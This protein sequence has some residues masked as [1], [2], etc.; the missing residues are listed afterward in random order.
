MVHN[1]K[2]RAERVVTVPT[3]RVCLLQSIKVPA[4]QSTL[5]PVHLQ[6]SD[7]SGKSMLLERDWSL[8][9]SIGL[10]LEDVLVQPTKEGIVHI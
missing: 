8:E 7:L 3:I 2:A 4:G 9:E 6:G 5:V 10:Q 1:V